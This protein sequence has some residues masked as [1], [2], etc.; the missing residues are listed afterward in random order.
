MS[1][2]SCGFS[3]LFFFFPFAFKRS[4]LDK[5]THS[6]ISNPINQI[7]PQMA[8]D[9][10]GK[11]DQEANLINAASYLEQMLGFILISGKYTRLMV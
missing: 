9:C 10:L 1:L 5:T 6:N 3:R 2:N 4:L 11:G 7:P 8:C